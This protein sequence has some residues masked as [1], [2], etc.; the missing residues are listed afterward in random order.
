MASN[1]KDGELD[2]LLISSEDG[3]VIRNMTD[4]FSLDY[5]FDYIT[6]PMARFNT[7]PWVSWSPVGDRIAY[8]ARNEKQKTL[9]LQSVVTS[10]IERRIEMASVDQPESPDIGPNGRRV[11]FSALRDGVGDIFLVDLD[12]KGAD[13][14]HPR[15]VWRLFADLLP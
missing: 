13:Q 9:I 14:P 7:A 8:F 2:I 12:T 10:K 3:E 1:R 6:T 5:G 11:V 15:R 4:G